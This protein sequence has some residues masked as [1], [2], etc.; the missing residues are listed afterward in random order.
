M[1]PA[2]LQFDPERYRAEVDLFDLTEA[3][4]RELLMTLWSIM[5]SFVELGFTVDVCAGLANGFAPVP[6]GGDRSTA[7]RPAFNTGDR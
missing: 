2:S 4:K 6:D 1:L 3:Q 7:I 5:R